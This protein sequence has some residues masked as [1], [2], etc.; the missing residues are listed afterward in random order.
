MVTNVL[1]V[2]LIVGMV[3]HSHCG[4]IILMV[5]PQTIIILTLGWYAQIAIVSL[6]HLELKITA[7]VVSLEGYRNTDN[8]HNMLKPNSLALSANGNT[9]GLQPEIESSILSI[10]NRFFSRRI[11]YVR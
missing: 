8:F 6:K 7:K 4:Q 5:M 1:V 2:E 9:S 3:S 11:Q 10:S